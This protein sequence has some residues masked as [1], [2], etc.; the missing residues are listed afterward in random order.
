[1]RKALLNAQG[2]VV[3]IVVA[4]DNW[5]PTEGLLIGPPGGEIGDVWDGSGYVRAEKPSE[6]ET[7]ADYAAAIQE[8]IDAMARARGYE[9]G[10][11]MAGYATDPLHAFEAQPFV[12]WRGQ[13]WVYAYGELAKVQDGQ[14]RQPSID[15]LVSEL[16]KIDWP[17]A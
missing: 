10:F 16:P 17:A 14:R 7:V 12:V 8:H 1:M 15:D 9:N 13:V 4:D 2:A 5:V 3:N 6:P 11:A